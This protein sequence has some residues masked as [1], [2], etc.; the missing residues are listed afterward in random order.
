MRAFA[1]VWVQGTICWNKP[2]LSSLSCRFLADVSKVVY[3][4]EMCTVCSMALKLELK[5]RLDTAKYVDACF[6]ITILYE[7]EREQKKKSVS[8]P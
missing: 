3:A 5:T 6:S 8:R 1:R 2:E 7:W 4:R